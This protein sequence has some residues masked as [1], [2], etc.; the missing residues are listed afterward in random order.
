MSKI[1]VVIAYANTLLEAGIK[2]ILSSIDN[3]G[4]IYSAYDEEKCNYIIRKFEGKLIIIINEKNALSSPLI[5]SIK[6]KNPDVRILLISDK[7]QID[8][9]EYN[10]EGFLTT[11]CD[12]EE[13]RDAILSIM[14]GE[15]IFCN[16]VISVIKR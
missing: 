7:S 15:K 9:S 13:I 8:T 3:I 5:N 10:I 12:E 11:D 4:K 6:S 1:N 2:S 14:Q 16:K